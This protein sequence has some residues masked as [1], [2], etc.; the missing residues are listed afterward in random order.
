MVLCRVAGASVQSGLLM[1]LLES[2]ELRD[3]H[4]AA[5]VQHVAVLVGKGARPVGLGKARI[6]GRFLCRIVRSRDD[7]PVNHFFGVV[8]AIG[9]DTA[10]LSVPQQKPGGLCKQSRIGG[11]GDA[12]A[13][14]EE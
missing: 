2:F 11:L 6:G 4:L 5:R 3:N 9:W 1:M 7:Q 14:Q 13:Q 8:D 10:A 12:V